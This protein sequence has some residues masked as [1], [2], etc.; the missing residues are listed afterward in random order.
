MRLSS[1]MLISAI[2]KL[3]RP[4][5]ASGSSPFSP[6]RCGCTLLG[7]PGSIMPSRWGRSDS[8]NSGSDSACGKATGSPPAFNTAFRYFSCKVC[9]RCPCTLFLHM[10]TPITGLLNI[11]PIPPSPLGLNYEHIASIQRFSVQYFLNLAVVSVIFK[12][13]ATLAKHFVC[14]Y[15]SIVDIISS[16][17]NGQIHGLQSMAG[18]SCKPIS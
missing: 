13:I 4:G 12:L 15:I 18:E 11:L 10:T 9:V 17:P 16:S 8:N 14:I 7:L 2:L 1:A 5:S 6:Y 3:S